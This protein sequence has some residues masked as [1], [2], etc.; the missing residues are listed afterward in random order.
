MEINY[1][2]WT[3]KGVLDKIPFDKPADGYIDI[4]FSDTAVPHY[5]KQFFRVSIQFEDSL[6][7]EACC[8]IRSP[9]HV[10][11]VVIIMKKDYEDSFRAWLAGDAK[12]LNSCC[13]RRELYCHEACHLVAIIR[14]FPSDR[15]SKVRDDFMGK[16][17]E[18]FRKSLKNA[19]G[20]NAVPLVSVEKPGSSPSVFDKDHF[21]YADDSLN[22][23]GLY[24]ELMLDYDR[25]LACV[26]K[27]CAGMNGGVSL[28]DVE[29]ETLVSQHF[30]HNFKE[31]LTQFIDLLTE[32]M[33]ANSG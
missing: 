14:A 13:R 23:F 1:V 24:Q 6:P 21:R 26:R 31:K 3:L 7:F 32:E 22:Y 12:A 30:F 20:L 10:V 33:G 17:K 28:E 25:M 11:T 9:S 8:T 19:A 5:I 4:N 2:L 27:L 18:K 16:I 15:S 29:R